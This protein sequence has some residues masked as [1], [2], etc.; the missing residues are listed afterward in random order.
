MTDTSPPLREV[1]FVALM[2]TLFATIAFSIDAM[3][4]ALPEIGRTLTPDA[5]N[6]AQLI[7]TSFVFGM[8][9]G[10][11]FAGPLSDAFGR[12]P[13]ILWAMGLYAIGA[14]LAWSASTLEGVLAG[15]ILQ[16]LGAAGPRVVTLALIRDIYSGR[17]MARIVSFVTMVFTLG[18]AIAPSLGAVIISFAGWRGIF[19]AFVVFCALSGLWF[20][21]RLPETHPPDRRR[22][23]IVTTLWAAVREVF[24][25]RVVVLTIAVQTLCFGMLFSVLSST[26]PVFDVTF[27]RADS[28]PLWFAGIA[29][30]AGMGGFLNARLVERL[31]MRYLVR[32]ALTGQIVISGLVVTL[33]TFSAVPEPLAFPIYLFW[34]TTVFF[35]AGLTI[36][37]LNAIAMEPLGHIA[38]MAAS[39]VGATATV[40]AVFIAI[41]IGLAFNGTPLPL[42]I[43]I[44]ICAI[45]GVGLMARIDR[46][47][48]IS[49]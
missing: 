21:L 24:A 16:G 33:W 36:G 25:N 8:G 31:G 28:F 41:P 26:Q 44:L 15:R 30:C 13:V 22:P 35:Q 27:G 9:V 12:K 37:N 17:R 38:G 1:E 48:R 43:G 45:L 39:V 6:R 42:A 47:E 46:H 11:L 3:L 40:L 19:G 23:L 18:P 10:T 49:V 2:A 5:P 32:T 34:T 20:G 4:P 7:L 14:V 29:I